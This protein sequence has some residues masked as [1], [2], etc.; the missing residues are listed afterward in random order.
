MILIRNMSD[1]TALQRTNM[2]SLENEIRS[3][4]VAVVVVIR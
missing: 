2:F 1:S 4:V 3:F